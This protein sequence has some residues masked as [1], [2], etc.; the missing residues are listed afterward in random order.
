LRRR[1]IGVGPRY[2]HAAHRVAAGDHAERNSHGVERRSLLD[3]QLEITV[4]RAAAHRMRAAIADRRKRVREAH[5]LSVAPVVDPG[6]A[7][8]PGKA[9]RAQ[10]RGLKARSFLV[11]PVDHLDG[12]AHPDAE[13]VERAQHLHAG[14]HAENAVEPSALGLGIEV[15]AD[16]NRR[17]RRIRPVAA[18]E[19]VAELIDG[20]RVAASAGPA[21]QE[22]ARRLVL[23]REREAPQPAIG[24]G[25]DPR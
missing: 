10:N 23:R 2:P 22:V 18:H 7:L 17:R 4:D 16:E 20:E 13:A 14:H 21:G 5:T 15:A 6:D 24:G 3:V 8:L 1:F 11:R 9:Q 25:A 12:A 19:H